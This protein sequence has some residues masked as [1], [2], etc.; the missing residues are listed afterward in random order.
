MT[1]QTLLP[2]PVLFFQEVLL[3]GVGARAALSQVVETVFVQYI[4]VLLEPTQEPVV[5]EPLEIT[6]VVGGA[7]EGLVVAE[8]EELGTPDPQVTLALLETLE[9][10]EIQDLLLLHQRQTVL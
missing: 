2:Q 6:L 9:V 4:K 10:L 5:V 3:V 8:E 1:L 7:E